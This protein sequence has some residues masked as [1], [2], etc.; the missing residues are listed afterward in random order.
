MDHIRIS[1][2]TC[3]YG[4]RI[5]VYRTI[6]PNSLCVIAPMLK[7]DSHSCAL[8]IMPLLNGGSL[9]MAFYPSLDR[10]N[11]EARKLE[12]RAEADYTRPRE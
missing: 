2:V 1:L 3:I 5:T 12:K 4:A 11:R 10:V 9:Y 8:R 6:L 7:V